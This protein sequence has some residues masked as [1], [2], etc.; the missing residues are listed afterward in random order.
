MGSLYRPKYCEGVGGDLTEVPRRPWRARPE[1]S[2]TENELVTP[3]KLSADP[4]R[5]L[6]AVAS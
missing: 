4:F 6:L 2:E 3:I 5:F 1:S